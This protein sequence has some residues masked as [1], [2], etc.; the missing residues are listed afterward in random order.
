LS[1][2][3]R[4]EFYIIADTRALG[5][6]GDVSG[7]HA[8][9]HGQGQHAAPGLS[10]AGGPPRAPALARAPR[11]S[12]PAA[13]GSPSA[14][15]VNTPAAAGA[16]VLRRHAE[17]RVA[18]HPTRRTTRG[19]TGQRPSVGPLEGHPRVEGFGARPRVSR[20]VTRRL[21]ARGKGQ[22]KR[23]TSASGRRGVP[24]AGARHGRASGRTS[25]AAR[26]GPSVLVIVKAPW[27]RGSRRARRGLLG[28]GPG[29]PATGR[30]GRS[31]PVA[32]RCGGAARPLLGSSPRA[33]GGRGPEAPGG[34]TPKPAG[35]GSSP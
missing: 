31:S 29:G 19:R 5:G 28:R 7:P 16:L 33:R 2:I 34:A 27:Q 3:A 24:A 25:A 17:A 20:Q 4:G 9:P 30:G 14:R 13:P 18:R 12:R 23:P 8:R 32:G 35:R 26:P 15:R 6:A 21:T 22:A 1:I 11:R 10:A